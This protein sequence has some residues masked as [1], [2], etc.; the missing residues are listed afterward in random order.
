MPEEVVW[1]DSDSPASSVARIETNRVPAPFEPEWPHLHRG[2]SEREVERKSV[3]LDA[4]VAGMETV[5]AN[6]LAGEGHK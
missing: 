2:V 5:M 6:H 1:R 4:H 3:D